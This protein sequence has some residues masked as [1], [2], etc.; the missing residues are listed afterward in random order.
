MEIFANLIVLSELVPLDI[1]ELFVVNFAVSDVLFK[2]IHVLILY[3]TFKLRNF[4]S[5]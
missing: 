5:S 2:F 4:T 3:F 1:L